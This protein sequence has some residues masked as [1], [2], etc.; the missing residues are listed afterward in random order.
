MSKRL[1]PVFIDLTQDALLKAFWYKPTLRLFLQQHGISESTLAQWHADQT[2]RAFVVWLFPKLLKSPR[3]H[4]VILAIA[5]TLVEMRHFPDLER[6]EDTKYL[7]PEAQV[8]VSRL[9]EQVQ[10][11]NESLKEEKDAELRRRRAQEDFERRLTSQK[12]LEKMQER[13]NDLV[14]L[15]GTQQGGYAFER[16]FYDLAVYFELDSRPGYVANGRQVD[17]AIT[18]EGTTYLVETK[19]T[20]EPIGSPAIDIFMARI[21][22]KADNTMGLFVSMSGFNSGALTEASKQRTPMLLLDHTHIY[23]L[24]LR[25]VMTL[26]QVVSRIKRHASQTGRAYLAGSEF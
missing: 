21:E 11:I 10:R 4:E 7:I 18:I 3:G 19:F 5:R 9:G 24:I 23:G 14:T 1:S 17:G 16:W 12:S 2:K 15:V 22:S 6:R 13:L 8:A 20:K 26:P 25:G